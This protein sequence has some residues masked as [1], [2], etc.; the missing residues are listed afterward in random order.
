[1]T[2]KFSVVRR[3]KLSNGFWSQ[4]VM[5]WPLVDGYDGVSH[6][7]ARVRGP[8]VV[9][10]QKYKFKGW[11][12]WKWIFWSPT[13]KSSRPQSGE[14]RGIEEKRFNFLPADERLFVIS[15][16]QLNVCVCTLGWW[17]SCHDCN[18]SPFDNVYKPWLWDFEYSG[19]LY[20]GFQTINASN[21]FLWK[22][23]MITRSKMRNKFF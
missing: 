16:D 17:S 11:W 21:H 18:I 14:K 22:A 10:C 1:M 9:W 2:V 5:I 12:K 3:A 19:S 6:Q 15:C 4:K 7:P 23:M 20:N 13:C 8:R